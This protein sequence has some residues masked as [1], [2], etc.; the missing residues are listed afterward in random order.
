MNA[1]WNF[2]KMVCKLSL[3][4]HHHQLSQDCQKKEYSD[5][6]YTS[7]SYVD[8]NRSNATLMPDYVY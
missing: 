7:I 4:N 5:S 6:Q 1:T 2:F 8:S 3:F